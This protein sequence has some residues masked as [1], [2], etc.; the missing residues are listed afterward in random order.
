MAP[1]RSTDASSSHH[2]HQNPTPQEA[3]KFSREQADVWPW[4]IAASSLSSAL[5]PHL[6]SNLQQLCHPRRGRVVRTRNS[7]SPFLPLLPPAFPISLSPARVPATRDPAA[8]MIEV[9]GH[10]ERGSWEKM[11]EQNR[12]APGDE[13]ER[14][15]GKGK[16]EQEMRR[17]THREARSP[18]SIRTKEIRKRSGEKSSRKSRTRE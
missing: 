12:R 8:K 16:V 2:L 5:L 18:S 13:G 4:I 17:H 6:G 7:L 11:G 15:G 1:D 3:R 14:G 10:R 9:H